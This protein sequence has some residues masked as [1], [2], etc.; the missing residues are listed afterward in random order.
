M[1]TTRVVLLTQP[2]STPGVVGVAAPTTPEMLKTS[3]PAI[4]RV[5]GFRIR[6]I[7]VGSDDIYTLACGDPPRNK[8]EA[9]KESYA[10]HRA[11]ARWMATTGQSDY[12]G[13]YVRVFCGGRLTRT[14]G[15]RARPRRRPARRSR[16]R[17]A[18]RCP[19]V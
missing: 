1:R 6:L 10:A 19:R 8:A 12:A 2:L 4:S 15:G 5:A 7:V 11:V 3:A 17:P 16:G 14:S 13:P 18:T 9:M